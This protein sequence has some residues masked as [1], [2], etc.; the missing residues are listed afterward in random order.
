VEAR[1]EPARVSAVAGLV[2]P[3]DWSFRARFRARFRRSRHEAWKRCEAWQYN[4][5]LAVARIFNMTVSFLG[6]VPVLGL[7]THANGRGRM[8][9]SSRMPTSCSI[10]R[11]WRSTSRRAG[12][13]SPHRACDGPGTPHGLRP[14]EEAR[15]PAVS[16]R[17]RAYVFSSRTR[18]RS[19]PA[20]KQ[21]RP[22]ASTYRARRWPSFGARLRS[23]PAPR[24]PG[25]PAGP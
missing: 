20:R 14:G 4:T 22:S 12:E 19:R 7:D 10:P 3:R 18:K 23:I 6:V 13:A 2:W 17:S 25:G 9:K 15:P 1:H 24:S 8:Q 5:R 16:R 21:R 11:R